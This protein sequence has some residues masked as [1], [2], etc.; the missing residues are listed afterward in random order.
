MGYINQDQA[1]K[2]GN[3]EVS[4]VAPGTVAKVIL[5]EYAPFQYGPMKDKTMP[6]HLGKDADTGAEYE[7][8]GFK[9]HDAWKEA[10]ANLDFEPGVTVFQVE[11]L[12]NG[13]KYPDYAIKIVSATKVKEEA[14]QAF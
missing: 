5:T 8:V 6:K 10:T 7:F 4:T 1:L 11:C 12:E 9:F 14:D 3:T 13:S 2:D